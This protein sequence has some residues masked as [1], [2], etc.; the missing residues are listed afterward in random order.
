MIYPARF[1]SLLFA[2]LICTASASSQ[3]FAST[4]PASNDKIHL[5]VVV[6]SKSGSAVSDLQK[7]DFTVLDNKIPKTIT[8]FHA[9]SG[10]KAPVQVILVVDTVN[11]P[12]QTLI[13]V[14]SQID[15]FLNADGGDLAHPTTLAF[16]TDKGVQLQEASAKNGKALSAYLDGYKFGLRSSERTDTFYGGTERYELSLAAL[17]Q[18]AVREATRPGRKVVLWLSPGWPSVSEDILQFDDQSKR[19][20]VFDNIVA[21]STQLRQAQMT[22]YS[23]DPVGTGDSLEH[24]SQYEPF[25]KGVSKPSQAEFGNL[26]LEVLVHQTG[27]LV[28]SSSN[29]ITNLLHQCVNDNVAYYELS[30]DAPAAE[31]R[32]EYHHLQVKVAKPDLVTRTRDGYYL[33]P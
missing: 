27:G 9:W 18:L 10:T 15:R 17:R 5:D 33:Q 23:V 22:L 12:Y 21:M 29:N 2:L 6:R 13:Q 7:Q 31:H 4:T 28:V 1:R 24:M 26:S 3:Q 11:T 30:F 25:L 16:F 32:D 19:Q 20:K 14:R 8:S